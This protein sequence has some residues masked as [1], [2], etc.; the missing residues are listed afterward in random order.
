MTQTLMVALI[1]AVAA[2]FMLRR[3]LRTLAAARAPR[4]GCGSDCGCGPRH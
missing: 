2:G 3:G 4:D 1:V